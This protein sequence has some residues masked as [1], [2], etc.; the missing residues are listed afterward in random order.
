[1]VSITNCL[2]A[3]TVNIASAGPPPGGNWTVRLRANGC[4][5]GLLVLLTAVVCTVPSGNFTPPDV[6]SI[7][8]PTVSLDAG[9][10]VPMPTLPDLS[11]LM[12]ESPIVLVLVHFVNCPAVPLPVTGVVLP[13]A[14]CTALP[15][16]AECW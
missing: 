6:L 2:P 10:V 7:T 11:S 8:P 12:L 16:M 14:G 5:A 9:E 13:A 1:M 3:G 4:S 15:F